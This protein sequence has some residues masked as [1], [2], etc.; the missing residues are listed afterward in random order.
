MPSTGLAKH[1]LTPE[2]RQAVLNAAATSYT[3]N[4]AAETDSSILSVLLASFSAS[5]VSLPHCLSLENRQVFLK[6]LEGQLVLLGQRE[7]ERLESAAEDEDDWVDADG[8]A[9]EDAT[10]FEASNNVIKNLLQQDGEGFPVGPLLPF[11]GWMTGASEAATHFALRLFSDIAE[12]NGAG[13][14][15]SIGTYQ[16]KVLG[17][18]V[19]SG[20]SSRFLF[21]DA[22][23]T[24]I[25]PQSPLLVVLQHSPLEQLLRALPLRLQSLGSRLSSLSSPS[26]ALSS[27]R[28]R[29]CSLLATMLSLPVSI[30]F[31]RS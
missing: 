13:A 8:W 18:V 11:L 14:L 26:L 15:A 5:I 4:I 24:A 27:R 10:V 30:P 17:A 7:K 25:R 23:L 22:S 31:I 20:S 16:A 3:E 21:C 12:F 1:E 2:D 29:P 6:A 28:I 19:A 9:D